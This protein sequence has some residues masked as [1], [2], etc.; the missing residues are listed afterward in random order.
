M[1]ESA[2]GTYVDGDDNDD[3]TDDHD[4]CVDRNIDCDCRSIDVVDVRADG[5]GAFN[6]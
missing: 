1:D 4:G 2:A 3:G 6:A 5:C